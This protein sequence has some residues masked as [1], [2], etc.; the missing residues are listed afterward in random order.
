MLGADL[1]FEKGLKECL[2][3]LKTAIPYDKAGIFIFEH[4]QYILLAADGFP[5]HC[6]S[7]LTLPSEHGLISQAAARRQPLA[8]DACP[9][10]I[11]G[12]KPPRYLDDVQSAIVAPLISDENTA[13]TLILAS[14]EPGRFTQEQAHSLEL[15]T[16]KLARTLVS[17]KTVKKVYL[18]AET[19][20]VTGLPNARAAF[21]KLEDEIK[22]ADREGQTVGVLFMDINGLKPVNDSYGHGAGD[23]LLIETAR[24]LKERLRTYDFAGRVGGDEFIAILPGISKSG[25]PGAIESLKRAVADNT[26]KVAEGVYAQ[27][28]ISIGATLFPDDST[29]PE[30]LVYLSDQRMYE[31]KERSRAT[32]REEAAP[33]LVEAG[34]V[35]E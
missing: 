14:T 29:D 30:E 7:R 3:I 28:T 2:R 24:R 10:E 4:G 8:A 33:T 21:R 15:I 31:D 27:T 12:E 5:D 16:R 1:Q 25:I 34:T 26:V 9:A 11:P 35:Q 22:R 18:E 20:A 19:D 17:S 13:G 32:R 6:I 23:Q